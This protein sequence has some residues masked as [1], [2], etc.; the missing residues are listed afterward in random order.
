LPRVGAIAGGG[1]DD[2]DQLAAATSARKEATTAT[3]SVTRYIQL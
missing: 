3:E 2:L 1:V